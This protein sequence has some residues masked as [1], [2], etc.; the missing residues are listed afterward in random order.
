VSRT[1]TAPDGIDPWEEELVDEASSVGAENGAEAIRCELIHATPGRIR[2]RFQA[3]E[4]QNGLGAAFEAFLRDKPGVERV[5]LNA[6][7]RS[8]VL[9][10]DPENLD[11]GALIAEIDALPVERLTD[12]RPTSGGGAEP[13]A[14]ELSWLNLGLSSA[15][16]VLGLLGESTVA[17]WLL[18][19]AAVP[20]FVRAFQSITERGKLNV[21]VLDAAATAVLA[22][23]AQF[24]TASA[25]VWLVSLGDF[26]RDL[27]LQRSQRAVLDLF[28]GHVHA[29]WV[30]RDGKKVQ[31][32]VEDIEE[33]EEVV[34]YPGEMIPVDG[35]VLRG[36][37]M[38]DQ[39][40]LTGESMP[41]EKRDGDLVYAATALRDGKLYLRASKVGDQ[42]MVA[43]VIQ[44]VR[45][46][47]LRETRAQNYAERFADKIVPWS[48]L[49]AGGAFLAT[50]NVG[51]AASLLIIDYGTGVR[52]AAPTGVLA[53]ITKAASQ[54]I[55]IKGGR[56][57]EQ[58]AQVDA[59]VFDKTGTL[60]AGQPAVVDV[61]PYGE[62]TT[63]DRVLAL[64][65]AAEERLTH[66][67]S[68]AIVRAARARDL[69]IPDRESSK[70]L[71]GL[72][73]QATVN[74]SEVL[75]GCGRFMTLHNVDV[76][77]AA[78]DI[79]RL[80][81][82]ATSPIFVARDGK[83]I[84]LLVCN[85][86]LR[87][88]AAEVIA[89]L[90]ARG[91][92]K[93]VMLTGDQP[94]VA[95][96]VAQKLGITRFI[97]DALPDEKSEFVRSLQR[98]G[99]TVAVIGDGINDSPALAQADVGIAVGGGADV[100]RETA[101]VA[102]LEGNLWKIPQ[103]IDIARESMG[104]IR[105]NWDFIFYGNTAAIA[106]SLPGLIGP[107]GATLISNGSAVLATLNA[108][109]PLFG[110]RRRPA[111][112][113]QRGEEPLQGVLDRGTNDSVG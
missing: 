48:F 46:A 52:V 86:P 111:L 2:I 33:G 45:E 100:A 82:E 64:A 56:Y 77:K 34:V 55:L 65:A 104:L 73:V 1:G 74:G 71:I 51:H 8:A 105:Q 3:R 31:V 22:S 28:D 70:Y 5:S 94:A 26:I 83:L 18:A 88:E 9:T 63:A 69:P 50:R 6:E 67:V 58:L 39:K 38:V 44:L 92:E 24:R 95:Q 41:V 113:D 30:V 53:S 85:D 107:I 11:P 93:V 102:L 4:L 80:T 57:L 36:H 90:R 25:M 40:M 12:Y 20:I 91:V 43:K 42:T 89:A 61:I 47:P 108:M 37:A 99:Y 103:V 110:G 49:G 62:R 75:V 13:A 78:R 84:G 14:E 106:L 19:G 29:A 17:P 15:A 79:R 96:E 23:Q 60:T 76:R 27:T 112:D 109:K 97:A 59:V 87:P 32:E 21:D 101:H 54:G 10:F 16:V 72:G 7:C 81:H 98:E 66:P 35:V 68:E